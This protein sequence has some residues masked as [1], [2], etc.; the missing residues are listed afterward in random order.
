[1]DLHGCAAETGSAGDPAR[2]EMTRPCA[3]K[4]LVSSFFWPIDALRKPPSAAAQTCI[5]PAT[6]WPA[7]ALPASSNRAAPALWLAGCRNRG[8]NGVAEE[9]DARHGLDVRQHR[10]SCRRD[11]RSGSAP[12]HCRTDTSSPFQWSRA[13]SSALSAFGLIHRRTHPVVHL[14]AER[15]LV[16]AARIPHKAK[17]GSS[18]CCSRRIAAARRRCT[19]ASTVSADVPGLARLKAMPPPPAARC[20]G[21]QQSTDRSAGPN[22]AR[23]LVIRAAQPLRG[24]CQG[25][26]AR[27][28]RQ[29]NGAGAQY[30]RFLPVQNNGPTAEDVAGPSSQLR[31]RGR[32]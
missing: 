7:S 5:P 2:R 8:T 25:Q 1:M 18:F 13:S 14:P 3:T 12:G 20:A 6:R 22:P 10:M 29:G 24:R 23:A 9:A 32:L 11:P 31:K 21:S 4:L 27:G 26:A 19:T 30:A 28:Q 16:A 15:D 17:S